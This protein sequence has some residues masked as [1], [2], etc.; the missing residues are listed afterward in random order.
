MRK[1]RKKRDK[2]YSDGQ[3]GTSANGTVECDEDGNL[4]SDDL[5]EL[6]GEEDFAAWRERGKE[7]VK[8]HLNHQWALGYWIV[9]GEELK[10]LAGITVDQR[11]KNSV[12]KAAA[13]ITGYSIKTVKSLA[14]VVRNIEEELK[15]E[16]R[17]SFAHFK[18]VA[19][20]SISV[21]QKRELLSEM[22]RS[23]LT[24][25]EG[26]AKVGF[27]LNSSPKPKRDSAADR[28]VAKAMEYCDQLAK[29]LDNSD[30]SDASPVPYNVLLFKLMDVR[31]AI[32]VV[33]DAAGREGLALV[34]NQR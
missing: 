20:P 34:S 22:E 7:L 28:G 31:H 21:D 12:Y 32:A 2:F 17:L 15:E 14:N 23:N 9:E 18:L 33:L 3:G 5:P 27:R 16:F 26:R 4:L 1:K 10:E 24:V 6:I 13:D 30:L 29:L 11:F 25:A 19:S 8:G